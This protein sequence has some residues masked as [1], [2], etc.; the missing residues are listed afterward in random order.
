M[1][2]KKRT[3]KRKR[4]ERRKRTRQIHVID[5]NTSYRDELLAR[6]ELTSFFLKRY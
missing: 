3:P 6:T 1:K 2:K 5:E 4:V